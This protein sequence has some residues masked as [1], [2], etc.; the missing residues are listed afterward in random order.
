MSRFRQIVVC[1]FEYE[2]APGGMP[3]PLCMVAHVLEGNFRHVR[4]IK[5]WRGEFARAPPFDIGPDTLFVAYSAWAE[6]MCFSVLNWRFPTHVYDLHTAYL[7]ASNVLLPRAR[8]EE[9]VKQPKD[10]ATA[11]R[12]YGIGGGWENLEK[13]VISRSIGDGSWRSKYTP[14]QVLTYCNEDVRMSVLLLQAQLKGYSADWLPPADV[15]RVIHWSEY[16]AKAIALIQGRGMYIDVPLWNLVQ[17]NRA[18]VVRRLLE[19]FDP[20]HNSA[21]PIYNENG[22]ASYARTERWL[23]NEGIDWPRHDNGELDLRADA[24]R[25]MY[26]VDPRIEG[27]HALRDSLGFVQKARLPIGPDGRNRPSLFPFGTATGRNAHARSPYNASAGM[28]PFMICPPGSQM[29][30]LDWNSQEVGIAAYQ[31]GNEVL[32][33]DSRRGDVY[34][35]LAVMCG[36]TNYT[37]PVAW[38]NDCGEQRQLMKRLELGL[39]YGMSIKSL[40]MG[41]KIHP[42]QA[43]AILQKH[44][45]RYPRLWEWRQEVIAHAL[46]DRIIR[47]EHTGWPL[48]LSIRPNR[49]TLM[50]F[51]LQ[52]GG[53]EMLRLAAVRLCEAGIVPVMLIHDGI[54]FEE[55][56]PEKLAH[57]REIMLQAGRD[58]CEGFEI[59]VGYSAI[60]MDPATGKITKKILSGGERYRDGRDMAQK[61]WATVM[62]A[63]EDIGA[64]GTTR[65]A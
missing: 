13:D 31:S 5:L 57:A 7:A 65:A 11:C 40:A 53:A 56:E 26:T 30:Y 29:Q 2:C 58:V 16:S 33:D 14:E 35:S 44:Q 19:R 34:H 24:F 49:R 27:W 43:A 36:K 50:N 10:F 9:R 63:L 59:G 15:Q 52:S 55:N 18:A 25:L 1:D 61:L 47:S 3:N 21:E 17:E 60:G 38:K 6:L 12:A 54:L 23:A 8:D 45:Q 28:R 22:E 64:K 42:C 39:R 4:T 62:G 37:D 20:S 32:K 51:P 41:L 48:R 46:R